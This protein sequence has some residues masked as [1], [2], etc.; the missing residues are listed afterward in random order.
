MKSTGAQRIAARGDG[1]VDFTNV[2]HRE[3]KM[4]ESPLNRTGTRWGWVSAA[5]VGLLL[6]AAAIYAFIPKWHRVQVLRSPNGQHVATLERSYQH[7]DVNFRIRLDGRQIHWSFDCA[8]RETLPFRETLAWDVNGEILTF[9]L[10]GEIVF[11]YD[12]RT[13]TEMP[14]SQFSSI[15]LPQVMLKDIGFEGLKDLR[16][17]QSAGKVE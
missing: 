17:K 11:A 10:C 5:G 15:V 8:P 14:P 7:I 13:E 9:E 3:L 1:G 2:T 4:A 12:V 16:Q 6:L